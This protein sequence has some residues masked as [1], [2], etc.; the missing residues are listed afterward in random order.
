MYDLLTVRTI[1]LSQRNT[2]TY[3]LIMVLRFD[4]ILYSNEVEL[5]GGSTCS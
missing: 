1:I 3:L 4:A 2:L 5:P